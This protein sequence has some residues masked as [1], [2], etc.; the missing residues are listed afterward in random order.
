MFAINKLPL[1]E[2]IVVII[3]LF[4]FFAFI[5][6]FWAGDMKS[7]CPDNRLTVTKGDGPEDSRQHHLHDFPGCQWL[8]KLRPCGRS[9]SALGEAMLM[10]SITDISV[11][12]RPY[13]VSHWRGCRCSFGKSPSALIY[14]PCAQDD[15]C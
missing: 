14:G 1:V 13:S 9:R 4:G 15:T 2:G 5:V 12:R 10:Q 8:G 6:I 11:Y 7:K 3:H